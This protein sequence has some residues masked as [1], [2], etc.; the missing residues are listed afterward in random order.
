MATDELNIPT[1]LD[2]LLDE[3]TIQGDVVG[4]WGFDPKLNFTRMGNEENNVWFFEQVFNFLRAFFG[5]VMPD[6]LE[7]STVNSKQQITRNNI[8]YMTFL[9][10][11]MLIMKTLKGPLWTLRLNLNLVGFFR[12]E[13]DPEKQVRIQIQEPVSFLVWGGPDETGFQSFSITYKIFSEQK[14]EGENS[15]LW[16]INQPLLERALKKWERQSRRKIEIVQGN[17]RR[18]PLGRHGFT[19]PAPANL[20]PDRELPKKEEQPPPKEDMVPDISDLI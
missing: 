14:L 9:D 12:S 10:E 20:K 13:A 19:K 8:N 17:N 15:L 18:L 5:L 1:S 7:L 3:V 11:L 4:S 6:S 16:S 2:D